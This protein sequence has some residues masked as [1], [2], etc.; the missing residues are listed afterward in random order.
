M[1]DEQMEMLAPNPKR[2]S[3][4]EEADGH[5]IEPSGASKK[6]IVKS[7]FSLKAL[8]NDCLTNVVAW[9]PSTS[10]LYNLQNTGD[11]LFTN[12]LNQSVTSLYFS[13]AYIGD[14][15]PHAI[16]EL[17]NAMLFCNL[18]VLYVNDCTMHCDGF[19][20]MALPSTLTE[21]VIKSATDYYNICDDHQHSVNAVGVSLPSLRRLR[22]DIYHLTNYPI[23]LEDSPSLT[24]LSLH[25]SNGDSVDTCQDLLAQVPQLTHL[26]IR[27]KYDNTSYWNN[28]INVDSVTS[29]TRLGLVNCHIVK[30]PPSIE[31]LKLWH[32]YDDLVGLMLVSNELP[33][34][35]LKH[36]EVSIVGSTDRTWPED[37]A[38]IGA[39]NLHTL[40]IGNPCDEI[41]RMNL[42]TMFPRVRRLN[43]TSYQ[44]PLFWSYIPDDALL[45][46]SDDRCW[47]NYRWNSDKWSEEI[48]RLQLEGRLAQSFAKMPCFGSIELGDMLKKDVC[49]TICEALPIHVINQAKQIMIPSCATAA[50]VVQH[51]T[52][53]SSIIVDFCNHYIDFSNCLEL[54]LL[55]V[56]CKEMPDAIK[57]TKL[58]LATVP[59]TLESLRCDPVVKSSKTRT[60]I[61]K[62]DK[63][64]I[65]TES[66]GVPCLP[67]ALI[68]RLNR[69]IDLECSFALYG[70]SSDFP[71]S[72][73]SLCLD[74]NYICPNTISE[75]E[76]LKQNRPALNFIAITG[77]PIDQETKHLLADSFR[78]DY[79]SANVAY[80]WRRKK[81]PSLINVEYD[82]PSWSDDSSSSASE[83]NLLI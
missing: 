6:P 32:S 50:R 9:L 61:L 53:A 27:Y 5:L 52:S 21:L 20:W 11:A 58:S 62:D 30:I 35:H 55:T 1:G 59:S 10:A 74:F 34:E 46:L 73:E 39:P 69:L 80:T 42:W 71:T 15:E 22:L 8:A 33:Y 57:S 4:F 41:L 45:M 43:L 54:E 76:W 28:D 83:V 14:N 79:G 38:K 63:L 25:P 29:L 18:R 75:L 82:Q 65:H 44:C 64:A 66:N 78:K 19:P 17:L 3:P 56:N 47:F 51:A 24:R 77:T 13:P 37:L 72:L 12:K 70:E 67:M 23:R 36:L 16:H 26:S 31:L 40:Y 48:D 49:N 68:A 60:W 81:R 7:H 2:K